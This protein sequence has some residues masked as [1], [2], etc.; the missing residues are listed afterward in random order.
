MYV[1]LRDNENRY[2][3]LCRVGFFVNIL[4]ELLDWLIIKFVRKYDVNQMV[5]ICYIVV[6]FC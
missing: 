4:K 6:Q 5:D 2:I 1:Q 3:K